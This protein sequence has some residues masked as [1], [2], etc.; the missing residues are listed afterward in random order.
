MEWLNI[1]KPGE[2]IYAKNHMD[3][4]V[5][6]IQPYVINDVK[7]F[8]AHISMELGVEKKV[9]VVISQEVHSIHTSMLSDWISQLEMDAHLPLL[10]WGIYY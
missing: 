5:M 8:S 1:S 3:S 7:Y 2:N 10:P 9:V 4:T 6:L